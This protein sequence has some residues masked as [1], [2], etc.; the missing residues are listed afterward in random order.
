MRYLIIVFCIVSTVYPEGYRAWQSAKAKPPTNNELAA[1]QEIKDRE[2]TMKALLLKNPKEMSKSELQEAKVYA[3]Q[4]KRLDFV[5]ACVE[6]LLVKEQSDKDQDPE[7]VRQLRLQLG[8][9]HFD[10]AD[11]KQAARAY[12]IYKKMYP[13]SKRDDLD[14]A[15]Y[16]EILCRF[17][18]SLKP[19]LDQTKTYRTLELANKYLESADHIYTQEVKNIRKNCYEYI[20]EYEKGI[21]IFNAKSKQPTEQRLSDL[22]KELE[23][24]AMEFEPQF[25][26]LEIELAQLQ[27]KPEIIEA[28]RAEKNEKFPQLTLTLADNGTRK[29]DFG[30]RF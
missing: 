17:Y 22:K 2:K 1:A 20:F 5:I 9:L 12:R 26:D 15:E 24:V 29:T 8:D 30:R 21:I 11:M 18:L 19:P 27:N 23:Q 25:L 7:L 10:N 28:K 13:G 4:T 14:H 6:T 3:I 16:K